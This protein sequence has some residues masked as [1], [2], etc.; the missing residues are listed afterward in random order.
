VELRVA[1]GLAL[2]GRADAYAAF[3]R[4]RPAGPS[5]EADLAA[6]ERDYA[7][8]VSIFTALQQA[9]SI[10]GTDLQTLD[11]NRRALERIRQERS[12]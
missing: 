10:Q 1:V 11:N 7:E 4:R 9:G 12:R 5:R 6:A 3:A 8:S 2:A